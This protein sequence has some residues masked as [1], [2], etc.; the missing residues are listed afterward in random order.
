MTATISPRAGAPGRRAAILAILAAAFWAS[1]LRAA[2]TAV[3]TAAVSARPGRWAQPLVRPGL[4]NFYKVSDDLYRGAQP[5]ARGLK[6]LGEFGVK[7]VVNLR[8]EHSDQDN[9]SPGIGYVPI[10]MSPM[11]PKEEDVVRFLK[12]VTDRKRVPVFLH[13][14]RG[15]DRTGFMAAAYRI[16]VQGWSREDAVREMREGGFHH[17][18]VYKSLRDFLGDLDVER[19]RDEAG[20][21]GNP[22]PVEG[23]ARKDR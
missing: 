9:L 1:P 14:A 18:S 7:T 22:E 20:L 11:K 12:V 23:K 5:T 4:P 16:V 2:P 17:A 8:E 6:G 3:S 19:I 10:P 15:A 21:K 13:C